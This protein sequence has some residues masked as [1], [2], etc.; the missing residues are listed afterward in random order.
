MDDE[1]RTTIQDFLCNIAHV[2]ED[3]SEDLAELL[4]DYLSERGYKIIDAI[5]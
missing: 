2:Q 4:Y 5:H 1:M 3:Q